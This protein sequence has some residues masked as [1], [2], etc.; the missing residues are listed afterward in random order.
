MFAQDSIE[1]L[2]TSGIDFDKFEKYGI[3]IHYF[4]ECLVMSGLVLNE[5]VKWLSFHS[6]YDFGYLLKTLTCAE[7][8]QDEASFLDMLTTYF[9]CI[10]DVKVR[11]L[12]RRCLM[13]FLWRCGHL[14]YLRLSHF[15]VR[16]FLHLLT[17]A[18]YDDGSGRHAR[19]PELPGGRA[20]GGAHRPHAPGGQR[21]LAHRADV[22]RAG[23]EAL[24]RC[25]R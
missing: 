10:Y 2:K 16:T 3:D 15:S 13:S 22:L 23:Q 6:S 11:I 17:A 9:P 25:R 21:L 8:A 7:L 1:L 18:V 19:W 14:V 4:G 20:A 5:D 24:P 12:E